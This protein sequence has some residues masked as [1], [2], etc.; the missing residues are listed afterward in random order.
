MKVLVACE[1]SGIVRE[2]FRKRGH[3]A[4]SC[5]LL[6][7]LTRNKELY[8]PREGYVMCQ[9]CLQQRLPQDIVQETIISPNWKNTGYRSPLRNYCKD[10]P[11]HV[12]DQMAH[13]G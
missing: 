9:Y 8:E 7:I 12:H 6:P 10:K 4:W 2:A 5:D 13:E 1:F 3:D 11:C